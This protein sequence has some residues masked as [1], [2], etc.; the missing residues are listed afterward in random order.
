VPSSRPRLQDDLRAAPSRDLR[1]AVRAPVVDDENRIAFGRELVERVEARSDSRGFVPL[2]RLGV[3]VPARNEAAGIGACLDSLREFAAA[4][5][6]VLVVDNG[7]T[8]DTAE[9]AR[10][11]GIEVVFEPRRG[12]GHALAT[13]YRAARDRSDWILFVHADMV[14]P[15]GTRAEMMRALDAHPSAVGGALGHRIEDPR[16]RFRLVEAGNRFRARR[17]K[18]SYGDQAQFWRV[19]AIEARG[20]FPEVERMEDLVLSARLKRA[21]E[22]LFLDLPVAIPARHWHRGVVS[23]TARNWWTTVRYLTTQDPT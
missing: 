8:D 3:V 14:L 13:G 11:R 4:G 7:S 5:D 10:G 23:T 22:I 20:G 12:R 15:P 17:L 9:V 21:G 18:L 2:V 1:G 6:P 16:L 19:F